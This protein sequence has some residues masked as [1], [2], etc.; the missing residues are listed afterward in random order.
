MKRRS[1]PNDFLG[2][3]FRTSPQF[4]MNLQA[5][6]DLSKV[7]IAERE[8]LAMIEPLVAPAGE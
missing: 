8:I 3:V 4:W 2:R 1:C 6:H 7:A 5:S